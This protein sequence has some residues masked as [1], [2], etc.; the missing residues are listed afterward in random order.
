MA[1]KKITQ[2]TALT[3]ATTAADDPLVIVDLSANETK[4]ID[5]SELFKAVPAGTVGAP[6]IAAQGDQNTGIYFPAADTL[7][8]VKGGVEAMRIDSAGNVLATTSNLYLNANGTYLYSRTA[9]G[10]AVRMLGINPSDVAYIGPIDPGPATTIFNA[11]STSINA[12]IFTGAIERMRIDPTGNVGIGVVP[13][14]WASG[15]YKGLEVSA[16]NA[17]S[18]NLVGGDS[19]M[20]SNSYISAIGTSRYLY[21]SVGANKYQFYN[22]THAWYN[23]PSGTAG[24]TITFTQAMTLNASGNLGVGTTNPIGQ[25]SASNAGAEGIEIDAKAVAGTGRIFA[26]NRSTLAEIVLQLR[27]SVQT[28]VTNALERMRIDVNG[29]VGIGTDTP[30]TFG[31]LAVAGN[32]VPTVTNSYSLGT[33]TYKWSNVHATTF[34]ENGFNVVSQTDLG[35]NPNE[36]P[37]NQYLGQLAYQDQLGLFNNLNTAPTV[38]SAS[39]IQPVSPIQF[40][41]GTT[42][43]VNITVPPEFA[44]G[45]GQLTLIPTGLWTTTT[46][47]NIALATTAVVNRAVTMFYDAATTKWYP[48]Y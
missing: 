17:A 37:L 41:S 24:N 44:V 19:S 43:I 38:L 15:T 25:L 1:D 3:G 18:V 13:S 33:A 11:S 7:S 23:A 20:M 46:A 45:G 48:S 6:S 10:G 26:Y 12:S 47:G 5:T 4:K 35:T 30:A 22:G 8:F 39:T 42:A 9:G 21:S 40:V 16:G 34:T 28:F 31:K 14:A 2:L 32:T 36:V 29:N 27:G